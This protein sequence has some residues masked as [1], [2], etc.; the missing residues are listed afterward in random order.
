[1]ANTTETETDAANEAHAA[2][3]VEMT[4]EELKAELQRTRDEQKR[5]AD[6][7]KK[8]NEEAKNSRLKLK[9][10]ERD[11]EKKRQAELPELERLKADAQ[12]EAE[13]RATAQRERDEARREVVAIRLDRMIE[14][15]AAGRDSAGQEF[16]N[17][18]LV[19]RLIERARIKFDEEGQ[20]VESSVKDA[21][22]RLAKDYP[23]LVRARGGGGSPAAMRTRQ[24]SGDGQGR[25]FSQIDPFEQDMASL[26]RVGGG[27]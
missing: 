5:T 18:E 7:L 12:R 22:A 3:A 6:A 19:P 11:E 24:A 21:V 15:E 17:P 27:M 16:L 26:G 14:R 8:V 25:A 2:E 1:M 13:D 4:A 20:P 9:D 23:N 10:Y